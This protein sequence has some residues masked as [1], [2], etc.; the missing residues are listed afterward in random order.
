MKK[1]PLIKFSFLVIIMSAVVLFANFLKL[2]KI[3][4]SVKVGLEN[5]PAQFADWKMA[6]N[7]IDRDVMKR[8]EFLNEV[9]MRTYV[10]SDGAVVWLAITYGSDQRQS[11]TI[12]LPEG[13]YRASGFDVET[14]G[15]RAV[16]NNNVQLK[17]LIARGQGVTEPISYWV[18]LDGLVVTNHMERK[19][20]QLYY[21]I[22]EKPAYGAL[23]R[24]SSLAHEGNTE[25][26]YEVQEDFIKKLAAGLPE[27]MRDTLFGNM[28]EHVKL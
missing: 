27:D 13:C 24:V 14:V 26:A 17:R 19:F 5:I 1:L 7:K 10:R 18:I 2:D 16:F 22:F 6:K 20:K 28:L 21:T 12:H 15:K 4:A 23:M 3:S 8:W 25:R 11:F 9:L